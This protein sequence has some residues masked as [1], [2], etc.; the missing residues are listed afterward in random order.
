[1]A[2]FDPYN[3]MLCFFVIHTAVLWRFAS[4][5]GEVAPPF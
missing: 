2:T 5:I 4:A 1:M 3:C